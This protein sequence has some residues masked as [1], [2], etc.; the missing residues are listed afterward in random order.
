MRKRLS[1]EN[2]R[3]SSRQKGKYIEDKVS[4]FG[5][6]KK[7]IV[8]LL[9][10]A[11]ALIAV[12][13]IVSLG[14]DKKAS[15]KLMESFDLFLHS[16]AAE[17]DAEYSQGYKI[18]VFTDSEIIHTSFNTLPDDL[19]INWKNISVAR[20]QTNQLNDTIERIKIVIND[21]SYTSANISGL[22]V[23]VILLRRKGSVGKLTRF[24]DLQFEAKIVEDEGSQLFCLLGLR[25]L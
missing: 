3:F 15:Q 8:E 13:F 20:I 14:P 7:Y 18:I 21:I 11:V 22:T 24:G 16:R 12:V 9:L 1:E 5:L 25:K 19:K 4:L 6:L 17:W 23:S 2:E 10:I